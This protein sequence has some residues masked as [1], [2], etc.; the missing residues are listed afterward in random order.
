MTVSPAISAVARRQI[1]SRLLER[2]LASLLVALSL[3]SCTA[4]GSTRLAAPP[5]AGRQGAQWLAGDHHVPSPVSVGW[6]KA[7]PP[8]PILGADATYPIPMNAIMARRFGLSWMVATDH[9]GPNHSKVNFEHAYPELL[10][11]RQWREHLGIRRSRKHSRLSAT[12]RI[13]PLSGT[14]GRA[15]STGS[16]RQWA[17]S[18]NDGP[19]RRLLGFDTRQ[20][21]RWWVTATSGFQS[22]GAT[23]AAISGPANIQRHTS[24]PR[25]STI[26]AGLRAGRVF[27]TT[28]DLISELS[29]TAAVEGRRNHIGKRRTL[30]RTVSAHD[31]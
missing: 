9:G 14:S 31:C 22:T 5:E 28:G 7:D 1:R 29:V 6:D 23:A 16:I 27:V 24:S 17:V 8:T 13:P 26:L 25:R 18:T 21:R 3:V 2:P 4:S 19:A 10:A 15:A 11:S 20:G 12:L 30:P